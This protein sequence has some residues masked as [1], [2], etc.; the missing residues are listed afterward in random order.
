GDVA[1]P[2]HALAPGAYVLLTAEGFAPG[3][4]GDVAP[5]PSATVLTL[6]SLGKSGLS[7]AGEALT[8]RSPEGDVVSRFPATPK[9]KAGASVARRRPDA[10]DDD[11]R[12]F[13]LTAPGGATPGGPNG[14]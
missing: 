12:A 2:A 9:P 5:P 6:P 13:A 4:G 14:L 3:A 10:P 1:L 8:L 7:N 11:A